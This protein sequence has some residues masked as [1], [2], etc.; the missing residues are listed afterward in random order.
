MRFVVHAKDK[1]DALTRRM[2]AL[3]AHRAHLEKAPGAFGVQ[4]LL[5]GPLIEDEGT[6]MIGSFFL[7]EAPDRESVLALFN[8]D[9]LKRA[10]VWETFVVDAVII[11]QDNLSGP[12]VS[13]LPNDDSNIAG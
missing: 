11:R 2:A 6:G 13:T 3:E 7:L 9:P 12:R 10:D 1:T 5:S 8:K 4:V